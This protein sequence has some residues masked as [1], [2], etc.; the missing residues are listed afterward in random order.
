MTNFIDAAPNY[1]A[2]GA[3]VSA[4]VFVIVYAS[5]SRWRAT[6][7]GRSLM[8]AMA[9]LASLLTMNTLHLMVG[10]YA[11]IN[12]VRFTVYTILLL[13]IWRLIFALI[14]VQRAGLRPILHPFLAR[15]NKE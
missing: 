15:K 8:G 1:I 12:W 11:A 5:F 13:S 9:A 2:G 7:P 10:D 14:G 4:W 3:A 6:T